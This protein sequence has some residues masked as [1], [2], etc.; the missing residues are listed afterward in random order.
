[1]F[2]L[3][4]PKPDW[5][6][7][8]RRCYSQPLFHLLATVELSLYLRTPILSF[9][10][11]LQFQWLPCAG[12]FLLAQYEQIQGCSSVIDVAPGLS[13]L[14]VPVERLVLDEPCPKASYMELDT[15][16]PQRSAGFVAFVDEKEC[17]LEVDGRC[18]D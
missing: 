8:D 2:I 16:E 5:M 13:V 1:M 12:L 9:L 18:T 6:G 10:H 7:L 17:P 4:R 11:W 14:P 3:H 15:E